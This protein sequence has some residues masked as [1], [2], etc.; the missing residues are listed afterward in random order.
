MHTVFENINHNV[1]LLSIGNP[2]STNALEFV[3]GKLILSEVAP[4]TKQNW[5]YVRDSAGHD[6]LI[7]AINCASL[8]ALVDWCSLPFSTDYW[9]GILDDVLPKITEKERYFFFDIADPSRRTDEELVETF[10]GLDE[11]NAYGKVTLGLNENE[12]E[13]VYTALNRNDSIQQDDSITMIENGQF[14]FRNIHVS[15]LLIHPTDRAISI[16]TDGVS[17]LSGRV[18]VQPKISTSGG[19]NFNNGY[20]SGQLI[21]LDNE[22]SLITCTANS[23]SYVQN[24]KSSSF[25]D[26]KDYILQWIKEIK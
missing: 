19:D 18:F 9:K 26:V 2:A 24:G 1:K 3:A 15:N 4:F 11:F 5:E 13:K 17:E 22:S 20:C 14:I 25:Q 10:D 21:G 7:N 23:G 8:I 6:K 12:T 16:N